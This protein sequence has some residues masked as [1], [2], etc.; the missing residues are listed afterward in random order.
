MNAW[1][2]QLA[3]IARAAAKKDRYSGMSNQKRL[4]AEKLDLIERTI[5]EGFSLAVDISRE[6]GINHG[7]IRSYLRV[8]ENAGR[9]QSTVG[10]R[11]TKKFTVT[12]SSSELLGE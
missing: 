12:S 2:Q 3:G 1:T 7:S 5:A 8:L 4:A 9:I 6:T 10:K 11:L